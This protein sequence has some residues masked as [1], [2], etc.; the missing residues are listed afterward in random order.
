MPSHLNCINRG[1]PDKIELIGDSTNVQLCFWRCRVQSRMST[2]H[3]NLNDEQKREVGVWLMDWWSEFHFGFKLL[4]IDK[5]SLCTPNVYDDIFQGEWCMHGG[6]HFTVMARVT[7]RWMNRSHCIDFNSL[8]PRFSSAE[9]CCHPQLM[10]S[11]IVLRVNYL[12]HKLTIWWQQILVKYSTFHSLWFLTS[13]G[14]LQN[15][16]KHAFGDTQ[17]SLFWLR[18]SKLRH[19]V[20]VH[21]GLDRSSKLH[22]QWWDLCKLQLLNGGKTLICMTVNVWKSIFK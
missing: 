18:W 19:L 1:N 2:P 17:K 16:W 22:D 15:T 10:C 4:E 20:E 14:V 21:Q 5:I 9:I 13:C 11:A 7:E 3:L 6:F 8:P 12:S